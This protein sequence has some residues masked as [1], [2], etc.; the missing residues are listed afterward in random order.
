VRRITGSGWA[1]MPVAEALAAARAVPGL[2]NPRP[3]LWGTV[4]GPGGILTVVGVDPD[5]GNPPC[6]PTPEKPLTTGEA[7]CGPGVVL[8]ETAVIALQNGPRS[9]TFKVIGRLPPRAGIAVQD[10]VVVSA[11]DARTLL[12]LAPGYASDLAADVFHPDEAQALLPELAAAFPWPVRIT[13]RA[14]TLGIYKAE[15]ANRGAL[16]YLVALPSLLAL[17]LLVLA[18]IRQGRGRRHEAGLLKCLGW[19][20]GDI[21]RL[22]IYRALVIGVPATIGGMAAAWLLALLPGASW[23]GTLLF[24]WSHL[25]PQLSLD[26]G[27][28]LLV[29]LEIGSLVLLPYLTAVLWSALQTAAADPWE[30]VNGEGE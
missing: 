26:S 6:A 24:G 10:I 12:G 28:A 5:R 25:P 9:M 21:V 20:T 1:P 30:L 17:I 29:L 14:E 27:G 23:T 7:C 4:R 8:D 19:T 13:T 11:A 2:L 3:R 18:V 22:Q 16:G 15:V